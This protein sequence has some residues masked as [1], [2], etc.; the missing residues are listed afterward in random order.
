[1]DN[2]LK[3]FFPEPPY[4]IE[5]FKQFTDIYLG[6]KMVVAISKD[7][8]DL[9]KGTHAHSSYEFLISM[10]PIFADVEKNNITW[11]QTN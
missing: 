3:R 9:P 6:S 7:C 4:P 10:S 2:R 1:M 8:V 11:K 5:V